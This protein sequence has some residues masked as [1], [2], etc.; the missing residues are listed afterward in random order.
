MNN[1]PAAPLVPPYAVHSLPVPYAPHTVRSPHTKLHTA[2]SCL[3][4]MRVRE[5]EAPGMRW[6]FTNGCFDILHAGHISCLYEARLLGGG[7]IVGLNSDASVRHNKGASRPIVAYEE[8][9]LLVAALECVDAV[10]SFD[11][12]TPCALLSLLRPHIHVK[13]GDYTAEHLP[14]YPLLCSWGG[15]VVILP[16]CSGHSTTG[17]IE[18]IRTT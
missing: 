9:A 8:R 15:E 13:G 4:F 3:A 7:L 16:Y 2:E 5:Q 1:A 12:D 11:E 6:V 14:E 18:R 10:L 17:I